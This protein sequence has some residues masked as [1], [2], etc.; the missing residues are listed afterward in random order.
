MRLFHI[1]T[2]EE[3]RGGETTDVYFRRT[4][5]VLR[6]KGLDRVRVV[7]EITSHSLP[8]G[9]PW[10]IL[11]GVEE[12]ARLLEGREVNVYSLPEGTVFRPEDAFGV[13][14][15]VMVLEG[16]YGE[17]CELETP[18]LGLLCQASGVATMAGRLR[19]L[20][21]K[22]LLIGFGMRRVH[23]ALAP[24][25][26]RASY[27]GGVDGVSSLAGAR[28]IGREPMGT[29]PH[30][31]IIVV[32]DQVRAWKAFDEVIPPEVPRVALVDTYFD[33]KTEAIL[34]AEALKDRLWGVRLDTPSSRRGNMA[35]LIREVRWELD[36]RGYSHVKILVSGG[37]N[38]E[39]LRELCEAG[40]DGFGVGTSLSNAPTIDFALDIVEKEGKPVAKRGKLGGRKEVWRC[41]RCLREVVLPL[42]RGPPAC[43]SCGS[44]CSPLLLPLIREGKVQPLPSVEEI[45]ERVLEQLE[46]LP[47]LP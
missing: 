32:G 8:R 37:I 40:A 21:G 30:A 23:P 18:L 42:G 25:V 33:E 31:L 11:C 14:V 43:P 12:A 34:A 13:R 24:M 36:L 45:R 19:K 35:T 41:E 16:P 22:K 44:P 17:F 26:D 1:A 27:I 4:M 28:A 6:A 46:K 29:M 5:Q 20:A 47:P 39:N 7:A 10:G 15:P 2:D 3:I 38:D 9:W